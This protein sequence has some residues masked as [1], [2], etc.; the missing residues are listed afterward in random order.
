MWKKEHIYIFLILRTDVSCTPTKSTT[1]PCPQVSLHVTCVYK[2]LGGREAPA[3]APALVLPELCG[4][5]DAASSAPKVLSGRR[6]EWVSRAYSSFLYWGLC[7]GHLANFSGSCWLVEEKEGKDLASARK[8]E[9]YEW[10]KWKNEKT[11]DISREGKAPHTIERV[12]EDLHK[13]QVSW[14]EGRNTA[15]MLKKYSQVMQNWLPCMY[16]KDSIRDPHNT[17]YAPICLTDDHR[18]V[19]HLLI[20]QDR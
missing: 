9:N 18:N 20:R 5:E 1:R 2:A 7:P 11:S 16:C 3:E 6:G 13:F 14:I 12:K 17:E 10:R 15:G 4:A 8:K 19:L